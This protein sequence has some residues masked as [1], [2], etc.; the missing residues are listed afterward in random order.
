MVGGPLPGQQNLFVQHP[1]LLFR[2]FEDHLLV[3]HRSA[4]KHEEVE[5]GDDGTDENDELGA[6]GEL[7]GEGSAHDFYS[8]KN[9]A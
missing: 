7:G 3:E 5:G 6:E 4:V 8:L 1:G 2:L 9:L